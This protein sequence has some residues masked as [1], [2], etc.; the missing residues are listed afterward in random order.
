MN[1]INIDGIYEASRLIA[2]R[3]TDGRG[4]AFYFDQAMR[5]FD[6]ELLPAQSITFSVFLNTPVMR[7][8]EATIHR[9]GRLEMRVAGEEV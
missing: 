6:C 2:N 1:N 3:T 8:G 7:A 9:D 5:A 4:S